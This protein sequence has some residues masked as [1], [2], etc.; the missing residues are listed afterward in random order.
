MD[1]DWSRY[2]CS[3]WGETACEIV[4]IKYD[5]FWSYV[6]SRGNYTAPQT[7]YL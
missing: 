3:L 5:W 1:H 7:Y 2:K 4:P 6:Y